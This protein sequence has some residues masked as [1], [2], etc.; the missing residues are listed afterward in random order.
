M[1]N[2]SPSQLVGMLQ[3]RMKLISY[4]WK[5]TSLHVKEMNKLLRE[6]ARVFGTDNTLMTPGEENESDELE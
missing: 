6:A 2:R 1:E 3:M 4:S 5:E